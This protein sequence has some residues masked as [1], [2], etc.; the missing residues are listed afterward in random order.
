MN[1]RG[2]VAD[3]IHQARRE[4]WAMGQF[5][6][7]SLD[8]LHGI[9]DAAN[10]AQLPCLVGVSMGT[11]RYA[12][13]E[14]IAGLMRAARTQATMPLYFHLDHGSDLDVV[15]RAIDAGFDSVMIDTSMLPYAENVAR[16]RETAEVTRAHGVALEAQLGETLDE[17]TGAGAQL[18][19]DPADVQRFVTETGIDYL[20]CSFGNAPGTG[21]GTGN[22]DRDLIARIGS[23]SPVPLV[24][25][26]GTSLSDEMA[27]FAIRCGAAKIN[28]DTWIRRAVSR[29][30]ARCYAN[31]DSVSDPRIP[32]KQVRAAV[33]EAVT[34]KLRLFRCDFA[35]AEARHGRRVDGSP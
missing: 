7:S 30:L 2:T 8:T 6:M 15:R 26:G 19:T 33:A 10:D 34:E 29:T 21:V 27:R 1:D 24:V 5:N 32:F 14:Y 22:P 17:E 13:M 3:L 9:V 16:V 18:D 12:G 4:G 25:H 20:A 31:G 28:I 35:H 11:L 23:A